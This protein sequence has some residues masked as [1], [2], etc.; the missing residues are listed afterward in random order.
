M[1]KKPVKS[2]AKVTPIPAE[3]EGATPYLIVAGAAKA[4][5]FYK[6][7][8]GAKELA[9]FDG[10]GGKVMHAEIQIGK[11]ARVM[12]ADEFPDMGA[13]SPRSLKGTPVG[14]L[15]YVADVD[16]FVKRAVAAGAKSQRKVE[17]MFY[18]DR[19]GTVADPFGHKWTF[20]THIE[21]VPV[22]EMKKRLASMMK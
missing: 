7:A 22:R 16:A 3:Y 13:V 4:L 14:L 6:K 19:A 17:D 11:T 2:K 21:D 8:F 5:A 10:P 20:A 9:R 18:G 15:V 1:A 12:L